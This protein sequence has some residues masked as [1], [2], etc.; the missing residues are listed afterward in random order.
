MAKPP[1]SPALRVCVLG[2]LQVLRDG[3]ALG[4]PP[5]R[6][7]RALLGYLA[8]TRRS[9]LRSRLCDLF[10]DGPGDPRASLRWSLAKLRPLVDSERKRLVAA[11]DG[12]ALALEPWELDL[13]EV[14]AAVEGGVEAAGLE[15]LRRAAEV[16]RGELLEGVE[17]PGCYRFEE[18]VAAERAQA[19]RLRLSILDALVARCESDLEEALVH[20]RARVAVDPL[21]ES[22]HASVIRVLARLGRVREGL[23]QYDACR[24]ILARALGARPSA[25][26]E[27]A[28]LALTPSR[29]SPPP[30]EPEPPKPAPR[31]PAPVLAGPTFVGRAQERAALD[32]I[33]AEVKGG[34]HAVLLVLGEPGVGKSR[35]LDELAVRFL[36]AGGTV[37]R[38]RAYEA[39]ALRPYAAWIDAL[40]AAPLATV[41]ETVRAELAALLP[42]LGPPGPSSEENRLFEAVVQALSTLSR[43]RPLALIL[44]DV[45]WFDERSAALLHYAERSLRGVPLL[46]ACAGRAAEL[47]DNPLA[48]KVARALSRGELVTRLELG[49]LSPDEIAELTESAAP[50]LDGARIYEESEGNPL[51]ALEMAR[52]LR[53]GSDPSGSLEALLEERF[54]HLQGR[55]REVLP[56]AAALGRSF[57][58]DRLARVAGMGAAELLPAVEELERRGV[59]KP[60]GEGAYDFTHDLVR[61]AA[62]RSL[63][64]P[65]RQLLHR[66]VARALS[67]LPDPDGALAGEIAHH[68]ALGEDA[69]LATQAAVGAAARATRLFAFAEARSLVERGLSLAVRLPP[70]QRI[71]VS[72]ALLRVAVDASRTAGGDASLVPRIEALLEEA[73]AQGLS[74]EEAAGY[75][76]LAHAHFANRDAEHA[77]ELLGSE[78]VRGVEPGG[79]AVAMAEVAGCLAILERDIP[80]ARMLIEETRRLGPLPPRAAVYLSAA[81]GIIRALEDDLPSAEECFERALGLAAEGAPWEECVLLARLAVVEL[82][83]ERPSRALE[84]AA[85][86]DAAAPRL[87]VTGE[88][89]VPRALGAVSRRL[90]GE[91]VGDETLL[92]VLGPLELDAKAR[93]AELV[94]VLAEGELASGHV[95]PSRALLARLAR[96]RAGGAI[97]ARGHEP[98]LAG[99]GR[100]RAR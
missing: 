52:A 68:A 97:V 59:L 86:M 73:R 22:G 2:D 16:F 47:A 56:W 63:S 49:P 10:W 79:A 83:L 17:V 100:V 71:S 96:R 23:E 89:L 8:V 92:R 5:S 67:P 84:C 55:A 1:A 33:V 44:D 53:T 40:R 81:T 15:A 35:L 4:L 50:G 93:F 88:V 9:Q 38:G 19:R 85:R 32:R 13:G 25:E 45:Q 24:Q 70:A 57:R 21:S 69:E 14:R 42:E 11:A 51:L 29:P 20:A 98:R 7:T 80:R 87:G 30:C 62:Y 37:A 91:N 74:A 43:E 28:R 94:C 90:M 41:N 61:R 76:I 46:L 31:A 27:R 77:A 12:V 72:L 78:A 26:I 65:R 18:W 75:G 54:E 6:R 34:R 60:A 39:E 36:R 99:Q 95:E 66:E 3:R 58:A 64:A 82:M 48:L